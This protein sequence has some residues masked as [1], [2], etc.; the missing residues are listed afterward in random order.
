MLKF[1]ISSPLQSW[2]APVNTAYRRTEL[3]PTESAILGMI[4][5]AFGVRRNEQTQFYQQMREQGLSIKVKTLKH[6][7]ELI[8]FQIAHYEKSPHKS[9][10]SKAK[11]SSIAAKRIWRYYLQDAKF[12][13]TLDGPQNVLINIKQALTHPKFALFLGRRS[14]PVAGPIIFPA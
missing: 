9:R 4:A 8:D 11:P 13:I 5:A 14:C 1:T 2:G 3:Q 12:E 10:Y 7:T 6:G